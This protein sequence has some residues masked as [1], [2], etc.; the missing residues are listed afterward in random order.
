[1]RIEDPSRQ[2]LSIKFTRCLVSL[3]ISVLFPLGHFPFATFFGSFGGDHHLYQRT[4]IRQ[5][6]FNFTRFMPNVPKFLSFFLGYVF[7]RLKQS[8]EEIVVEVD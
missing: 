3:G 6:A 8:P 7:L 2:L 1:M 5:L 4:T